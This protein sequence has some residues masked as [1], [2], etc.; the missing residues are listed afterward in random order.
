MLIPATC[1]SIRILL[2]YVWCM[3]GAFMGWERRF[4]Y[5]E[6]GGKVGGACGVDE[7]WRE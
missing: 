6:K 1:L 2:F 4:G 5:G 7:V 3:R